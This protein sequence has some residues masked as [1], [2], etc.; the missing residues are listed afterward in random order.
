[1][2]NKLK[3]LKNHQNF[4]KYLKNTSWLLFEKILRMTVGLFVG[5][6]IARYLGPEQFGL[7]SYAQSFVGLFSIIAALGLDSIIVRELV[8][9]ESK[10]DELINTAF[11]LKLIGAFIVL[12]LLSIAINF[13]SNDSYTNSLIFII[14]SATVFQ[15]FNVVDFYFQS[16]V[17]SKYIVYTNIFS[18]FLSSIVKIYLI[19]NEASL[20]AFAWVIL[21]DS[22]ILATG[23]LYFYIQKTSSFTMKYLSFNYNL[24]IS[25]LKN[26]LPLIIS[27][28][29]VSIYMKIDQVMIKEILGN[30]AVGQ[31]AAATRLSEAWYFIPVII[32]ASLF[33]AIIHAKTQ[34]KDIYHQKLQKLYD[35]MVLIAF[36]IAIPMTFIATWVIDILY[37]SDFKASGNVLII[38]I[39]SGAFVFLTV[40]SGKFL[41]AE[42]MVMKTF[43]RNA[44]AM[45]INIILNMYLIESYGI[46]GAA[47]ATLISWI[48]SGYLY[49]LFDKEIRFMFFQKT[50]SL[51]GYSIFMK[52]RGNNEK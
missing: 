11:F 26:S 18:L 47:I 1:M 4:M 9:N 13:T 44:L 48:I 29:V 12:I 40:A 46:E 50:K 33:P 32:S 17:L 7:F 24:G 39:W 36:S 43:Y 41:I 3:S 37:G 45:I 35:L 22:F 6:W 31:Y 15:S 23:F 34:N 49:D 52:I 27:S 20:E 16:Q 19:L 28:I 8:K 21:F 10:K 2:L 30:E 38:H 51:V 25:L 14:A 42:N 5:V